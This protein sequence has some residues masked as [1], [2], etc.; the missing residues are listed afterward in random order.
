MN[1][2]PTKTTAGQAGHYAMDTFAALQKKRKRSEENGPASPVKA[3]APRS[4][5]RRPLS[6]WNK[7]GAEKMPQEP[8]MKK[9]KVAEVEAVD[10][11]SNQTT[12][13]HA[14]WQQKAGQLQNEM[15]KLLEDNDK[16]STDLDR[17]VREREVLVQRLVV[18]QESEMNLKQQLTRKATEEEK[19]WVSFDDEM[20]KLE[21]QHAETIKKFEKS[22]ADLSESLQAQQRE[23]DRMKKE[24]AFLGQP[25]DVSLQY[26]FKSAAEHVQGVYRAPTQAERMEQEK[27]RFQGVMPVITFEHLPERYANFNESL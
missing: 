10:L 26:L 22:I 6:P 18:A 8:A 5:M 15:Q 25:R 12:R 4:P 3:T 19:M 20:L 11:E 23:L 27:L 14:D 7:S 9:V 1:P 17:L 13:Q 2:S 16:L 24:Q 21:H